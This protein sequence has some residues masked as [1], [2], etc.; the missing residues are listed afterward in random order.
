MLTNF[1]KFCRKLR[2]DKG[3]LLYDMAQR[4]KVSSAFLSKVENG[5]AKPPKEWKESITSMYSLNE[6]QKE[7]LCEYIDEAR[8][9]S[10]INVSSFSRDDRDMMFAFARKLDSMDEDAKKAWKGLLNM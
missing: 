8:E 7:E 2:I 9:S 3:E 10:I 4:L 1:G 6:E 5:K